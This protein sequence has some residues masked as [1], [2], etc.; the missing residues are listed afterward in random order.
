MEDPKFYLKRPDEKQK[1]KSFQLICYLMLNRN[2]KKYL[3]LS[4][5]LKSD[6]ASINKKMHEKEIT[7]VEAEVLFNDLIDSQYRKSKVQKTAIKAVKLSDTNL[8][9]LN[10]FWTEIYEVK[11]HADG[12]A[13]ARSDFARTFKA[14]EP[15]S[16]QSASQNDIQTAL[17]KNLSNSDQIIRAS[18]R[19]NEV[20][21]W[22]KRDFKLNKPKPTRKIVNHHTKAE[23]YKMLPHI[24]CPECKLL[25]ETLFATGVRIGESMALLDSDLNGTELGVF[26]QK[27]TYGKKEIKLPKRE[28]VG[29]IAVFEFGLKAVQGWIGVEDK[30]GHRYHIGDQLTAACLKGKVKRVTP[31]DL[32]H[33]HS[34]MIL[35][36]GGTLT[37]VSLNIRDR[38]E[39]CQKYYTG[40]SHS[41]GTLDRLKRLTSGKK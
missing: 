37:D 20:L 38:I 28:K 12:L 41:E 31:H 27:V 8:K 13:S 35:S 11:Y 32:R 17:R 24:E 36:V 4:D 39:T 7:L 19:L 34:I 18:D 10:K 25:A 3:E 14:I 26:K 29:L 15:Q 5:S 9:V 23:F 2:D 33:S 1:R 22:L 30:W 6:V 40:Y 21:K 16:I